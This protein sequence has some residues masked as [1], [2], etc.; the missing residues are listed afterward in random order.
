MVAAER[1]QAVFLMAGLQ[2]SDEQPELAS[3]LAEPMLQ[4]RVFA[5]GP[6]EDVPALLAASDL[7]VLSSIQEALPNVVMEA[8]SAGLPCVVTD[9][10]DAGRMIGDTGWLVAPGDDDALADAMIR[11]LDETPAQRAARGEGARNRA[12][13]HFGLA[14][15]TARYA[16]LYRALG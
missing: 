9:V 3:L 14:A 7:Y 12:A 1:P 10:G 8:M 2:V 16:A 4:G 5:L 11:A 6:R 15:V 13:A